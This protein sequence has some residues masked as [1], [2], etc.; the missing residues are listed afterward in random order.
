MNSRI[1]TDATGKEVSRNEYEPK[2]KWSK[3]RE[4]K[5]SVDRERIKVRDKT[6]I[7]LL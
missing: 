3:S 2:L 4:T 5:K 7:F 1:Y 6:R